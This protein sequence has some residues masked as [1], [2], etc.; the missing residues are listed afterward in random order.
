M[1]SSMSLASGNPRCF[2]STDEG[3]RAAQ[4]GAEALSRAAKSLLRSTIVLAMVGLSFVEPR[5]LPLFALT[6]P[7]WIALELEIR[8]DA[9]MA[10]RFTLR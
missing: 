1:S 3:K 5:L 4:E 7:F 9:K 6:V 8:L 2:L 10:R